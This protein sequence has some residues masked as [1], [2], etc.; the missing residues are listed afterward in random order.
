MKKTNGLEMVDEFLLAIGINTGINE[1]RT[2]MILY[3]YIIY[4]FILRVFKNGET[5]VE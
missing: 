1:C 5:S 4:L 2:V 3:D